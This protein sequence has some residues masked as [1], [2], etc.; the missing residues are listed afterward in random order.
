MKAEELKSKI[1]Y[2][3][4]TSIYS[5]PTSLGFK[6]YDNATEKCLKI[7]EEYTRIQIEKDREA[8][9]SQALKWESHD[10]DSCACSCR[11]DWVVNNPDSIRNL[12]INL[13]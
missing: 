5:D 9:I 8:V 7:I 1:R 10:C 2:A 11:G 4:A 3:I 13:D 6:G 12:P